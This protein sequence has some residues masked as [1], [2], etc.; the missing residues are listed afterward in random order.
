MIGAFFSLCTAAL[1]IPDRP[2]KASDGIAVFPQYQ[3]QYGTFQNFL[4][5]WKDRPLFIDRS[6][7]YPGTAFS[8]M[9]APSVLA[10]AGLAQSYGIAG[11]TPLGRT[12]LIRQ[13]LGF[14]RDGGISGIHIMPGL[15]H[16]RGNL[17]LK[18]QIVD[19][20][21]NAGNAP[22]LWRIGGRV[23]IN[24]YEATWLKPEEIRKELAEARAAVGDTFAFIVDL[25]IPG[26]NFYNR[27]VRNGYRFTEQDAADYMRMLETWLAAGDGIYVYAIGKK[28]DPDGEYG[29]RYDSTYFQAVRPLLLEVLAR[30]QNHG[31]I[32][33]VIC[34]LGYV[35]EK[36]GKVNCAEEGTRTFRENF[37][38]ALSLN[39]DFIVP[40]EWNEWNENTSF[41]PSVYK[42]ASMRRLIRYYLNTIRGRKNTPQQGEEKSSVPN[43]VLSYRYSLKIGEALPFE[44]LNIPD[45]AGPEKFTVKLRLRTP[46]GRVVR[47]F[48]EAAFERDEFR[49]ETF[50]IPTEE[51]AEEEVLIPELTVS[52]AG[53]TQNFPGLL[54]IR[55][56]PS[57][58][59]VYQY[60]RSALRECAAPDRCVLKTT[61][62]S[63]D[64]FRLEGEFASPEL[65]RSVEL[66]DNR[67]E[68]RAVETAPEFDQEKE[69]VLSMSA[70]AMPFHG[71]KL[72]GTVRILNVSHVHA[73]SASIDGNNEIFQFKP[74]ADGLKFHGQVIGHGERRIFLAFPRAELDKAVLSFDMTIGKFRVPVKTIVEN[75]VW[76]KA[77]PKLVYLRFDRIDNLPDIPFL[78]RRNKGRFSF[79]V[80]SSEPLP[81][82]HLRM[83]TE[84]GKIF[85]SRPSVQAP[86]LSG[87]KT[88]MVVYS[89]TLRKP[90]RIALPSEYVRRLVYDFSDRAGDV[91]TV[92]ERKFHAETGGGYT[93][94]NPFISARAMSGDSVNAAPGRLFED[95]KWVLV[96]D[97]KAN[98]A[99][100]PVEAFPRGAYTMTCEFQPDD[101][102]DRVL[103]RHYGAAPASLSLFFRDGELLGALLVSPTGG[104]KFF[105]TGLR[106]KPGE[107]NQLKVTNDL[108]TLTFELNGG[109]KSFPSPGRGMFFGPSVLGGHAVPYGLSGRGPCHF[110]KGKIR[111]FEILHNTVAPPS[112]P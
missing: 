2:G 3:M 106:I 112:L 99:T 42:G 57:V 58:N 86:S 10:N 7:R 19:L 77:L 52:T 62:L 76:A 59:A 8:Y 63:K 25:K 83:I 61:R 4:H 48:P 78:L 108:K 43:L 17:T 102:E 51:F 24:S 38:D 109:K 98:N 103:F 91:L 31:K 74:I 72:V 9:T 69:I 50:R 56:D 100:L 53:K 34:Q 93:Y 39:P 55:L 14:W 16:R 44:L 6:H 104:T 40:F 18:S 111:H 47:E 75:G 66:L 64:T 67:D 65:L 49:A 87:K 94:C 37:E 110:F 79:V 105:R 81:V 90:V 21:K 82:F 89:E 5:H 12:R 27:Y 96:F 95:G 26:A 35:N 70:N 101:A 29:S 22:Q 107:W 60:V 13:M 41:M 84:S 23:V 15:Y 1:E 36:S 97:G 68:L 45:G 20:M 28:F 85:H 80:R 46:S 11:F 71:Q 92:P 30:K 32:M 54:Y 73:R 88:P 33:G